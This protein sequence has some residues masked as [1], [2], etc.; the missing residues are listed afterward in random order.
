MTKTIAFR[1][2]ERVAG[3]QTDFF[4]AYGS[5]PALDFEDDISFH[6]LKPLN[7]RQER[8]IERFLE[9]VGNKEVEVAPGLYCYTIADGSDDYFYVKISF[10]TRN[11]YRRVT[12]AVQDNMDKVMRALLQKLTAEA[13]ELVERINK[14]KSDSMVVYHPLQRISP[15]HMSVG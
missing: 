8:M 11:Q 9:K 2:I 5:T 6:A 10:T 12:P 15:F 13:E 3:F 7:K 1:K 14:V 4:L